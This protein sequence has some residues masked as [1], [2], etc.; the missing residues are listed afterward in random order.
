MCGEDD[1]NPAMR[2]EDHL[3]DSFLA[4]SRNVLAASE[5]TRL[6]K[7]STAEYAE[8]LF[9]DALMRCNRDCERLD[10]ERRYETL[11]I[12]PMVFARLAGFLASHLALNEDPLRKVVEATMHGYGEAEKLAPEHGHFHD[13]ET[14]YDHQHRT[15]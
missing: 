14:G 6:S 1:D 3:Y 2:F 12:Q 4:H 5:R 8:R 11:A 7:G 10:P 13:D 15:P 9:A